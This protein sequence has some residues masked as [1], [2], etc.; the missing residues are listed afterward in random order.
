MSQM[1]WWILLYCYSPFGSV[2]SRTL[3][4]PVYIAHMFV[5]LG[6]PH[7]RWS[8]GSLMLPW[9]LDE[10]R[11][12]EGSPRPRALNGYLAL[13][14]SESYSSNIHSMWTSI[15]GLRSQ[16]LMWKWLPIVQGMFSMRALQ[17]RTSHLPSLEW[18][19]RILL[20]M[21]TE[22]SHFSLKSQHSWERQTVWLHQG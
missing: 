1:G 16:D 12:C 9:N 6:P 21:H 17:W 22:E 2:C 8:Q 4:F 5:F 19:Y 20:V 10:P 3:G 7:T 13:T 14:I 11:V 15:S 18:T